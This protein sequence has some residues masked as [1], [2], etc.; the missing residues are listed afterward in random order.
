[1]PAPAEV[2]PPPD[3]TPAAAAPLTEAPEVLL[4]L[5]ARVLPPAA[6]AASRLPR[7]G[8][9]GLLAE[10]GLAPGLLPVPGRLA[11]GGCTTTPAAA[12]ASFRC[13]M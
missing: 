4:A 13:I 8:E 1:M 9:E 2:S 11:S 7:A 5:L 10:P 6:A 12:S 3:D